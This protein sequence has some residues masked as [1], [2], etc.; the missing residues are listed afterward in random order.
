MPLTASYYEMTYH[1]WTFISEY[2]LPD[3]Q[4][5]EVVVKSRSCLITSAGKRL[6]AKGEAEDTES[7]RIFVSR[8]EFGSPYQ[9]N[10]LGGSIYHPYCWFARWVD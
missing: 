10:G 5:L 3:R 1:P 4:S 2:P 7:W 6:I 9:A 8:L